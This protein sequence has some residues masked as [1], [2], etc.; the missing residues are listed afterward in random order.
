MQFRLAY[1]GA[2]DESPVAWIEI[3]ENVPWRRF[4]KD[5][6]MGGYGRIIYYDIVGGTASD[7]YGFHKSVLMLSGASLAGRVVNNNGEY[8]EGL[9]D[10]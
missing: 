1:E 8:M 7:L 2:V 6:M 5:G 4:G 9:P 10:T 3:F